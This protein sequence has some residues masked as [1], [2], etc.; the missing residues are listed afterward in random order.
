LAPAARAAQKSGA[1]AAATRP[2][3][4]DVRLARSVVRLENGLT[5]LMQPDPTLPVVGV[6]VWIRG[7]SREEAA[8][9]FGVAHLFEHH[10]PSSGRFFRNAEN[11]ALYTRTSRNGNAG[12]EPDF[13]R[14]Y[15]EATPDGLEAVLA[16]LA[17]RLESDP[18]SFTSERLKRD[19]DIV[20][21]E[22]RRGAGTEWDVEVRALLHRGTFGVAHPY[23]HAVSGSEAEVR[24]ATVEL[25]QDWHRRFAGAANS[26]VL[27]SGNFDPPAAEAM[28]RRL[29]GPIQPGQTAAR[30]T[31]WVPRPRPLREVIEKDVRQG[32]V[33]LSWPVPAWG[34][35]AGDYLNLFATVLSRRV[36]RRASEPAAPLSAPRA[37]VELWELAGAFTLKGAFADAG[38]ADAAESLLRAE[39]EGLLREGP[40]APELALARAQLQSEFVRRLQQPAW[41]GGRTDVLGLGLLYRGD[42]DIYRA[43]LARVAEA[44]PEAVAREGRRW[45]SEPSYVLRVLPRPARA[46]A[47]TVE[48]GATL[49]A[50]EPR[51]APFPRVLDATLPNGMRM[52]LAERPQLPLVQ[53]TLA[54]DAGSAADDASNA[55]RARVALNALTRQAVAP[56]GATLK[57]ALEALGA[58]LDTRLD[59]DFASVSLSVLSDRLE[60]AV[61]LLGAASARAA[62]DAVVQEARREA[63]KELEAALKE[64]LRLRVRALACALDAGAACN[65]GALDGLGTRA[66]L[67][68]LSTEA[69]RRFYAERYAPANAV[70]VVSG[71][72]NRESMAALV[73]R[74]FP[75]RGAHARADAHANTPGAEARPGGFVVV[76][77]PGAP[78]AHLLLALRLPA[79]VAADPLRAEVL[80]RALR[81]R[82]ADNLRGSKGWSYDV[83]PYGVEVRR[84]GALMNF[85]MPLQVDKTAEAVAEIRAEL[86]RLVDEP[87]TAEFMDGVKSGAEGGLVTGALTSLEQLNAQLLEIIRGGRPAGYYA[88]ALG[89]LPKL[90]PEDLRRDAQ[91]MLDAGRLIWVIAG[92]RA[93]VGR[94]LREAGVEDFRVVGAA[95]VP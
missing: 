81:T 38:A 31:E 83:Y 36:G 23:G 10:L 85:S 66:G 15:S 45:L 65:P 16:A 32:A 7:G 43:R 68:R 57:D 39:L 79:E 6:E 35:D 78:Q 28:V 59:E 55:G 67:E 69:V 94:E 30:P 8:G 5:L 1:G 17:D 50:P 47:G 56:N 58:R 93:A 11:R 24:A 75:G 70:L 82:L 40:S 74:A 41:R 27:V 71:D 88:E 53:L 12:T 90:T 72:V 62:G 42:P 76:D 26:L 49:K 18:K 48:R 14:F 33:Y 95:D 29:F 89:A 34:S 2:A 80:A 61:R 86:K 19:Q 77:Y 46:A 25:M 9:Q 22:L 21:N 63:L 4:P 54:F 91:R 87:V 20:V 64:P 3:A 92:D 84:R 52:L 51:P 73:G 37:E 60:E 13:V 44:T